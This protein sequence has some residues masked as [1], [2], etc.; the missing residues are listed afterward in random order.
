MSG[1]PAAIAASITA[2]TCWYAIPGAA[3]TSRAEQSGLAVFHSQRAAPMAATSGAPLHEVAKRI[4]LASP[5]QAPS[6]RSP[7]TGIGHVLPPAAGSVA[8]GAAVGG[9]GAGACAGAGSGAE[10]ATGGGSLFFSSLAFV[11]PASITTTRTSLF[12]PPP[13]AEL[14][15]GSRSARVPTMHGDPGAVDRFLRGLARRI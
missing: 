5:T 11:Q 13:T 1:W 7:I 10:G 12:M 8:V 15:S 4:C 14:G 2:T 9:V 3:A 6:L